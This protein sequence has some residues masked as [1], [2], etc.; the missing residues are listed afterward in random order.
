[1]KNKKLLIIGSVALIIILGIIIWFYSKN[2][3]SS[4]GSIAEP[5]AI[6]SD[7]GIAKYGFAL[8]E[9]GICF[10][11]DDFSLNFYDLN[12]LEIRKIAD[13]TTADSAKVVAST[14]GCMVEYFLTNSNSLYYFT[15]SQTTAQKINI[16]PA[17]PISVNND[18]FSVPSSDAITVFNAA[19]QQVQK[20][21]NNEGEIFQIAPTDEK[22]YFMISPY[23]AEVMDGSLTFSDANKSR[24]VSNVDS[25]ISLFANPN[26]AL[27]TY[28]N[29][30]FTSAKLV[31]SSGK[32]LA[33]IP[34]IDPDSIYSTDDGYYYLAPRDEKFERN[35]SLH[36]MQNNGNDTIIV[37]A[38]QKATD[39]TTNFAITGD[40][41]FYNVDET[42]KKVKI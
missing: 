36:Y 37:D 14:Q 24:V 27:Y 12:K 22:S 40:S 18:F 32:V 9:N 35:Y 10:V 30:D 42:I 33:Q 41:V 29:E 19:G 20:I 16:E 21:T 17:S 8:T 11:K 1:M 26:S 7:S 25:I 39:I 34:Q 2:N 15:A 13:A 38:I 3:S 23:D 5:S 4:T 28:S 31:N 6:F